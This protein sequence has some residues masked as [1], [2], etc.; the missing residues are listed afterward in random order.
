MP[1]LLVRQQISYVFVTPKPPCGGIRLWLTTVR[2]YKLYLLTY[3]LTSVQQPGFEC[4]WLS[5]LGFG[6]RTSLSHADTGCRR[7]A[8]T[9]DLNIHRGLAFSRT[10]WMKQL[11]RGAKEWLL[12]FLQKD[13]TSKFKQLLWWGFYDFTHHCTDAE[14]DI[15][16]LLRDLKLQTWAI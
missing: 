2:V 6:V 4:C 7:S 12:A 5:D 10:C 13:I 14:S 1:V 3:L 11:I 9:S 16:G 15:S 8:E